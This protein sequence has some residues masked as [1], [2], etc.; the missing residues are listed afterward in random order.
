MEAFNSIVLIFL[1]AWFTVSFTPLHGILNLIISSTSKRP[2]LNFI[3]YFISSILSCQKCTAL[4]IGI[5]I[6][7]DIYLSLIASFISMLYEKYISSL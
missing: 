6:T 7:G 3:F 1:A 5:V 2:A 4:W